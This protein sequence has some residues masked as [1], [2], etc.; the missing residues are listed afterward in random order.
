MKKYK[1]LEFVC[2]KCEHHLFVNERQGW[3]K[4]VLEPCPA[5]G[6]ELD[7]W[8]GTFALVGYGSF[9]DWSGPKI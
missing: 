5:C 9:K 6:E 8:D 2:K 7:D 4:R 3:V 1:E